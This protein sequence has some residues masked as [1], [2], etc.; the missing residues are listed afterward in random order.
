MCLSLAAIFLQYL[1]VVTTALV[2]NRGRRHAAEVAAFGIDPGRGFD[3]VAAD[4][5]DV[6]AIPNQ[7]KA[8]FPQDES[9]PS[10]NTREAPGVNPVA[11]ARDA[12]VRTL[13][14]LS[15]F[16]KSINGLSGQLLRLVVLPL[17]Q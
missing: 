16:S 12:W 14:N 15:T 11:P 5:R 4:E 10:G 2:G 17:L 9:V 13:L 6:Q 7:N 1:L 3:D 8:G